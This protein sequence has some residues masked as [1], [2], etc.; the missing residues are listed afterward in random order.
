MVKLTHICHGKLSPKGSNDVLQEA[1]GG[2]SEHNII[3]V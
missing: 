3:D 1:G 2:S